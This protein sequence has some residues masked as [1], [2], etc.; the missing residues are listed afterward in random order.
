MRRTRTIVLTAALALGMTLASTAAHAVPQP[1]A[2]RA[3]PGAPVTKVTVEELPA[4]QSAELDAYLATLSA[5]ERQEVIDT[6]LP[7]AVRSVERSVLT[8]RSEGTT[9]NATYCYTGRRD[10]SILGGIGNTLVTYYHVGRWCIKSGKVVAAEIADHG[11]QPVSA[12]WRGGEVIN[13]GA[14]L[15]SGEGRSYTQ[16]KFTF[17]TGGWDILEERP[18]VRVNGRSNA[19]YTSNGTCGIY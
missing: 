9:L 2:D 6:Q 13:K 18:C 11:G 14:G 16:F 1:I 12:G 3:L 5:N 8:S 4:V 10:M 15:L 19:T 7:V 17:G